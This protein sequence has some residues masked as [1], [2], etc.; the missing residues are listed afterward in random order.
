MQSAIRH[1]TQ[2]TLLAALLAVMIGP[3]T[4]LAQS[5]SAG[6]SIGNDEKSLSGSRSVEPERPARRSKPDTEE[7]RRSTSRRSGGGGGGGGGGNFDGAWVVVSVG[8]TCSGS[9]STA[10]VVSSGKIIGQGLTGSVSPGGATSSVGNYDGI[11]VVSSGHVSGRSG[12]GSFKR[13][14]GCVGRWTASKQ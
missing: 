6:G 11:T 1:L 9:S 8:T 13:S 3:G 2:I 7:P 10:V 14:D 12:S 4:A 5:G